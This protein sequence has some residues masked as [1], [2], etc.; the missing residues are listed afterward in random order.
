MSFVSYQALNLA[1][2]IQFQGKLQEMFAWEF[3]NTVET[4]AL[5]S[6]ANI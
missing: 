6:Q 4:V 3:G 5:L 2:Q 1:N